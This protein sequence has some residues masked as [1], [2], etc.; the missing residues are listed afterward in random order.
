MRN[1]M[2]GRIKRSCLFEIY[3]CRMK[4]KAAGKKIRRCFFHD[5]I[6]PKNRNKLTGGINNPQTTRK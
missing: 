1:G 3:E 5:L 4:N 2:N 6:N